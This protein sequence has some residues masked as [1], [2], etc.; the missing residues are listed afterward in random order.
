MLVM[1]GEERSKDSCVKKE[2]IRLL[3]TSLSPCKLSPGAVLEN[4]LISRHSLSLHLSLMA[5]TNVD[6]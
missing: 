1:R 4:S 5:A 6:W 2:A 3:S